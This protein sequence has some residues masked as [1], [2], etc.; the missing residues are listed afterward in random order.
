MVGRKRISICILEIIF[1]YFENVM[2][3]SHE[4]PIVMFE[5]D[6]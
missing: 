6:I 1:S 2:V 4:D 5:N 3:K